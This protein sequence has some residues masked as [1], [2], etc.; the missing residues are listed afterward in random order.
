MA[1][2]WLA[3]WWKEEMR[4]LGVFE[5]VPHPKEKKGGLTMGVKWGEGFKD[6][7]GVKFKDTS[8]VEVSSDG[9]LIRRSDLPDGFV[10]GDEIEMSFPDKNQILLKKK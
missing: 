1:K 3:N 9:I 7:D 2:K 4:S 5:S 8:T 10:E 6:T